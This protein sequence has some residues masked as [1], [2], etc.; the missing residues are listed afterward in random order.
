MKLKKLISASLVALLLAGCGSTGTST[1]TSDTPSSSSTTSS[2]TESS[3]SSSSEDTTVV[4]EEVNELIGSRLALKANLEAQWNSLKTSSYEVNINDNGTLKNTKAS[5]YTNGYQLKETTTFDNE[6]TLRTTTE[7]LFGDAYVKALETTDYFSIERYKVVETV[8]E[9]YGDQLSSEEGGKKLSNSLNTVTL[10]QKYGYSTGFMTTINSSMATDISYSLTRDGNTYSIEAKVLVP[11]TK[12]TTNV[13]EFTLVLEHT[14]GAFLPTAS[15]YSRSTYA[16]EQVNEDGTVAEGATPTKTKTGEIANISYETLTTYELPTEFNQYFVTEISGL[17]LIHEYYDENGKAHTGEANKL[18]AGQYFAAP[19]FTEASNIVPSTAA[20]L[21]TLV[22]TNIE[23]ETEDFLTPDGWGD[24]TVTNEIGATATLTFGNSFN[25]NVYS[26]FVE[27]VSTTAG[28][29]DSNL[30]SPEF[31]G[32]IS[33]V[34]YE[35]EYEYDSRWN[36]TGI[37]F[38]GNVGD[39]FII[40]FETDNE[41]PFD[42]SNYFVG[43]LN[44][45]HNA[46]IAENQEQYYVNTWDSY[47]VY[48]E[49]TLGSLNEDWLV[50]LTSNETTVF[51]IHITVVEA[52]G[53]NEGGEGGDTLPTPEFN[54][55]VDVKSG[56]VEFVYDSKWNVI[57]AKLSGN[58]GDTFVLRFDTDNEGPFDLSNY[59]TGFE[60]DTHIGGFAEDQEKYYD[61]KWDA[62]SVYFEITLASTESDNL[63]VMEMNGTLV[64]YFLITVV[65]ENGGSEGGDDV[66]GNEPLP[67]PQFNNFIDVKEGHVEFEYDSKYNVIAAEL[68]GGI[69]DTFVLKFE[70]DNEGPFDLS[71]YL[72]GFENDT[73][74]GGFAEDQEQYYEGKWDSYA[75]YFEITLASLQADNLVVMEMN[76]NILFYFELLVIQGGEEGGE[77]GEE[78]GNEDLPTPAFNNMLSVID[79]NA[80]YTTNSN[81]ELESII[82]TGSVGDTFVLAFETDNEGPFNIG[83]Y[84]SGFML[85][86]HIGGIA[87]NQAQYYTHEWAT[88]AVYVEITLGS[89]LEDIFVIADES[90]NII[91][92]LAV[93]VVY[94]EGGSAEETGAPDFNGFFTDVT[95]GVDFE[96][97]SLY[98]VQAIV[99]NGKIGDTF[100][101][102]VETDSEG[103]FNLEGYIAGAAEGNQDVRIAEN[104]EQYYETEWDTYAVY[105][106]ITIT[107]ETND[108]FVILDPMYNVLVNVELK[109][110]IQ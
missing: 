64:Y 80:E 39:K 75:V 23:S 63:V 68:Y 19:D 96:Y 46:T 15:T 105:I 59:L 50:M 92:E 56:E 36:I 37:E 98:Q 67:A 107:S 78:G 90:E 55:Y 70:T 11:A 69:G 34:D 83:N 17:D 6:T 12:T 32:F 94:E 52:E 5:L 31:N 27:V 48:V 109:V 104:Q 102:G 103:P 82:L 9:N 28:G 45:A 110:N 43:C 73:H 49:F 2:T 65:S 13:D 7:G 18:F 62:Y 41:G 76:G 85:G 61:S 79:G 87:E 74:I 86:N 35:P 26:A 29:G 91:Y 4:P 106:E 81:W 25:A 97:D 71:N 24:Y 33:C 10:L 20:D 40:K 21:D 44:G 47:A 66:G 3:T 88:Y 54:N 14:D 93:E 101:I 57:E 22:V 60:N 72:T 77:G 42:L 89:N 53:G 1:T 108:W 51:E 84:I 95:G 99:L 100:V 58:V 38:E 16:I 30:P 8:N